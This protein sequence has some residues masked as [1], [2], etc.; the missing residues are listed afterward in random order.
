[1]PSKKMKVTAIPPVNDKNEEI[2]D[3][4]LAALTKLDANNKQMDDLEKKLKADVENEW[5]RACNY[6]SFPRQAHNRALE[7]LPLGAKKNTLPVKGKSSLGLISS[8]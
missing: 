3:L 4:I 7:I 6:A 2:K 5:S 1:M 8:K